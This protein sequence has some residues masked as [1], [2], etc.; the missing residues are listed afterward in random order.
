M[1]GSFLSSA[2]M[3]EGVPVRGDPQSR[4]RRASLAG[5]RKRRA[6]EQWSGR[7]E[8][9]RILSKFTARFMLDPPTRLELTFS[10]LSRNNSSCSRDGTGSP[11]R[12]NWT[13]GE[14]WNDAV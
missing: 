11:F 6:P 12:K 13:T 3:R 14:S 5:E 1:Q 4:H 8:R 9:E 10:S 7:R 2:R